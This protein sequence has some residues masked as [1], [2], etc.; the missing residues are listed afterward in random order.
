MYIL[1]YCCIAFSLVYRCIDM[2]KHRERETLRI[3]NERNGGPV[4]VN[5]SSHTTRQGRLAPPDQL[6][7]RNSYSSGSGG[8]SLIILGVILSN[9]SPRLLG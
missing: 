2:K 3:M 1:L 6:S 4:S 7:I 8:E 9:V 5:G